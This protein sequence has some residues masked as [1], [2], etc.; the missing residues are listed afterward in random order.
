MAT[1][2]PLA[3]M[4]AK[5]DHMYAQLSLH[6]EH[7][8]K[9]YKSG[10]TVPLKNMKAVLPAITDDEARLKAALGKLFTYA[11][12]PSKAFVHPLNPDFQKRDVLIRWHGPWH[13]AKVLNKPS[14]DAPLMKFKGKEYKPTALV[15]YY[16]DKAEGDALLIPDN[17]YVEGAI[18]EF[19]TW[20]LL[21]PRPLQSAVAAEEV[22]APPSKRA[23]SRD[24]RA[25]GRHETARKKPADPHAPT[26][27][28]HQKVSQR[29]K[30]KPA[31]NA[32]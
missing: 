12:C 18:S 24:K 31:A 28:V 29:N 11:E 6:V 25:G 5:D 32:P 4:V 10:G 30:R 23:A 21:E 3:E 14:P 19:G 7:L 2:R 8:Y 1:F 15:Y 17:Y 13:R 26:G 9:H 27:R 20:V 16:T 22:R